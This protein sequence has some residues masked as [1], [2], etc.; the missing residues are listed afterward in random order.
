[1]P[2]TD[3][4]L[5]RHTVNLARLRAAVGTG[6]QLEYA[7]VN[8]FGIVAITR[9]A[10][11]LNAT[12]KEVLKDDCGTR[13]V[14]FDLFEGATTE[15]DWDRLSTA[16]TQVQLTSRSVAFR[17][18]HP[19]AD[20]SAASYSWLSVTDHGEAA[21][22]ITRAAQTNQPDDI[23]ELAYR[24]GRRYRFGRF[25][26]QGEGHLLEL[27]DDTTLDQIR[28]WLAALLPIDESRACAAVT[29]ALRVKL[30][31]ATIHV[32]TSA[33]TLSSAAQ[34]TNNGRTITIKVG[35]GDGDFVEVGLPRRPS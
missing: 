22:F 34:Y 32:P 12:I 26:I 21:L 2:F 19:T 30:L 10:P 29:E 20:P 15:S 27:E 33:S 28:D 9:D 17:I 1:M 4:D 7:F 11:A 13:V 18:D 3:Q 5:L 35:L 8:R 16:F 14:V 25:Y 23:A 31:A 24:I 6:A